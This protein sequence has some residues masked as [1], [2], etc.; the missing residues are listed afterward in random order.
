MFIDEK[1]ELNVQYSVDDYV[2]GLMFIQN[3]QF[4]FRYGFLI[5]PAIILFLAGF[6]FILNSQNQTRF[7]FID[8]LPFIISGILIFIFM[9]LLKKF[10]NPFLKWNIKRQFK[11]S[12]VLQEPQSIS[13]DDGGITGKNNLSSGETKWMAIIKSMETEDNF[14]FFTSNKMAMFIPKRF[15]TDIQT[16]QLRDI[17]KR[18][19]GD[20]AKL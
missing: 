12:P 14:F 2:S 9:L 16:N 7:D 5:H 20:R 10:P 1:I 19:L 11:S 3:Q 13:I 18:N 15:L 17:A 6:F 4:W 8:Y